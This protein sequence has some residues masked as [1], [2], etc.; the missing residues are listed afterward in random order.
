M[1]MM[2][3][4][5]IAIVLSIV[6]GALAAPTTLLLATFGLDP[7]KVFVDNLSPG[8]QAEFNLTIYNRDAATV[9]YTISAREPDYTTEGYD[10]LPFPEWVSFDRET[11]TIEGGDAIPV[12]VT[13]AMP[14]DADYSAKRS[15]VWIS[16]KEAESEAT[17]QV[18]LASRVMI[19]T[20]DES[21][22][23]SDKT[24]APK[25]ISSGSVGISASG[26]LN[27]DAGNSAG[28]SPWAV[29]GIVVFV[30]VGGTAAY[31]LINKRRRARSA[32]R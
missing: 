30:L 13:I 28:M 11:V 17:I 25:V 2:K 12:L 32:A 27:P 15:E 26:Q 3:K 29:V 1:N 14:E 22:P 31:L 23:V 20:R 6:V 21:T 18:E 10:A 9:S 7:G 19:T 8:S 4:I 16:I 24:E 5:A